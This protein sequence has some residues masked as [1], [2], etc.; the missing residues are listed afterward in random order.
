MS[1]PW[2]GTLC[3]GL[4]DERLLQGSSLLVSAP[5]PLLSLQ[6]TEYWGDH[7]SCRPL[8]DTS[9]CESFTRLVKLGSLTSTW[10]REGRA[11]AFHQGPRPVFQFYGPTYL[12]CGVRS[13]H[14]P[15]HVGVPVISA[16]SSPFSARGWLGRQASPLLPAGLSSRDTNAPGLPTRPNHHLKKKKKANRNQSVLQTSRTAWRLQ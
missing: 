16:F 15:L 2:P 4:V 7:F 11:P 5:H 3:Q 1:P 10:S 13:P 9:P 8:P 6:G 14:S 12:R